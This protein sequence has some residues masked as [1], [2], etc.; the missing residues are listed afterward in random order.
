MEGGQDGQRR[1]DECPMIN[2]VDA[3]TLSNLQSALIIQWFLT[4]KG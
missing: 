4:S 3:K 2:F 1:E